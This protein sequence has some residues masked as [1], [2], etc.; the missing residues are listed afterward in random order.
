MPKRE[1]PSRKVLECYA[2]AILDFVCCHS[3]ANAQVGAEGD[4]TYYK[5]RSPTVPLEWIDASG[6][7]ENSIFGNLSRPCRSSKK[8]ETR[9]ILAES[10]TSRHAASFETAPTLSMSARSFDSYASEDTLK[11]GNI[12]HHGCRLHEKATGS[13]ASSDSIFGHPLYQ[14]HVGR[15]NI[16]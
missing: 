8:E 15:D 16:I 6:E 4:Q 12:A 14:F 13:I 1:I 9:M 7:K 10:N 11:S 3:Y 2:N 5:A